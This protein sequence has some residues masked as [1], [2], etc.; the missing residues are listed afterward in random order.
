M[1]LKHK[2]KA[3]PQK[4]DGIHFASKAEAA[5]YRHLQNAECLGELLFFLR[6]VPLHLPGASRYV[7]DFVEFWANGD[8]QFTDVKGM[9]T[10][11]YKLKKRQVEELYPITIN[12]VKKVPK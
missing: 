12:V 9:E 4:I 10:Q 2:F 7:V 1:P 3:K 11:L 6:Q 8:I 5:Y